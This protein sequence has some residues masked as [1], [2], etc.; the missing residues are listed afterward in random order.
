[1]A[2]AWRAGHLPYTVI[3]DNKPIGIY[4]IFAVFQALFGNSIVSIRIATIFFVALLGFTVFRI[5]ETITRDRAAAWF[6]GIA[7]LL[8]SLSNDGLSAN[9]ECFMASFTALAV[10]AALTG[11]TTSAA[12]LVGLLIGAAFMVKYV[13]VF[14]APAIFA[15][16]IWRRKRIGAGAMV[17]LGAAIPLATVMLVYALAGAFPLWLE[18]S[19]LSNFRRV[20]EAA[21][22]GALDYALHLQ[23]WRWAR[24][25][26]GGRRK[27]FW[28]PGCSAARLGWPPPDRSTTIIFCRS[29]RCSA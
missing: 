18:C 19:V 29:C 5:T 26:A 2:D 10:L 12:L 11:E 1:M 20:G 9:T 25:G 15:L 3:W 14:E 28:R 8:C 16:V 21:N 23:L 22:P 27:Y 4:A 6:A 7:L 13:A 17:I 24:P